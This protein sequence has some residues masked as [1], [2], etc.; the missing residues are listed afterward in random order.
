MAPATAANPVGRLPWEQSN[1]DDDEDIYG[2]S[3]L[4]PP[5]RQE[6]AWQP[7]EEWD[8]RGAVRSAEVAAWLR[9]AG[10]LPLLLGECLHEELLRRA[11][12]LLGALIEH[13]ALETDELDALWDATLNNH[14]SVRAAL[15]SVLGAVAPRLPSALVLRL[16]T[17]LRNYLQSGPKRLSCAP[18]CKSAARSPPP[19]PNGSPSRCGDC[20][21]SRR[22]R[23]RRWSPWPSCC[24]RR[25]TRAIRC[26][27][28]RRR[29]AAV[30]CSSACAASTTGRAC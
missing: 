17:S 16:L 11:E 12:P 22:R 26:S 29:C 20:A 28:A 18:S 27:I 8:P 15:A 21:P 9:E 23:R 19:P 4:L 3:G 6:S 25:R 30:F 5:R 10:V 1:Y 13:G 24:A 7:D 14:A 2:P